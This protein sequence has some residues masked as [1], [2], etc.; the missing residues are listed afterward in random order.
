MLTFHFAAMDNPCM[1]NDKCGQMATFNWNPHPSA[2]F[3]MCDSC[4]DRV[5]GWVLLLH[6][7]TEELPGLL[8]MPRIVDS[9]WK[10]NALSPI[11]HSPA[12]MLLCLLPEYQCIQRDGVWYPKP[13]TV[14]GVVSYNANDPQQC[15]CCNR[16]VPVVHLSSGLV[17]CPACYRECWTF[18]EGMSRP[19]DDA[20]RWS[21]CIALYCTLC[22]KA[23]SETDGTT[24]DWCQSCSVSIS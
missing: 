18:R 21:E 24:C 9:R 17:L 4:A 23:M 14:G 11:D 2:C 1:N 15:T 10:S 7:N 16:C 13:P 5:V 6:T 19:A 3:Q 20:C 8:G 12:P 22:G